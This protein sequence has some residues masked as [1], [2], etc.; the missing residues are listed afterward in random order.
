MIPNSFIHADLYIDNNEFEMKF[1]SI[2]KH[3]VTLTFFI[4]SWVF[5]VPAG[6][7]FLNRGEILLLDVQYNGIHLAT[8][9]VEISDSSLTFQDT[10]DLAESILPYFSGSLSLI[11]EELSKKQALHTKRYCDTY[12]SQCAPLDTFSFIYDS[13]SNILTLFIPSKY[14]K[15]F[16]STGISYFT[17]NN[18]QERAIL[19]SNSLSLRTDFEKITDYSLRT[20]FTTGLSNDSYIYASGYTSNSSTNK[21]DLSSLYIRNDLDNRFYLKAG[22]LLANSQSDISEGLFNYNLLPRQEIIGLQFGTGMHRLDSNRLSKGNVIEVFTV[23]GGRADVYQNNLYLSSINL[24]P[25]Y[26]EV[27]TSSILTN[28]NGYIDLHI[29]ENGNLVRVESHS[30]VKNSRLSDGLPQFLIKA[31]M[32]DNNK[33][34][35]EFA[36]WYD[37]SQHLNW[38]NDISVSSQVSSDN[39]LSEFGASTR[40]SYYIANGSPI[41][42]SN[43]ARFMLGRINDDFVQ[44]QT[45]DTSLSLMNSSLSYRYKNYDSQRCSYESSQTCLKESLVNFSTFFYDT[46]FSMEHEIKKTSLDKEI[47]STNRRQRST[48]SI[49]KQLPL[50]GVNAR[51]SSSLSHIKYNQNLQE[52]FYYVNLSLSLRDN[53]DFYSFNSTYRDDGIGMSA[54]YNYTGLNQNYNI[55]ADQHTTQGTSLHASSSHEMF[56][57]GKLSSSL[58][59]SDYNKSAYLGYSLGLVMTESGHFS[60]GQANINDSSS[61]V[62]FRSIEDKLPSFEIKD[63]SKSTVI[64]SESNSFLYT[65]KSY[66]RKSYNINET[67]LIESNYSDT[68]QLGTG[69]RELFLTPGHTLTH[70]LSSI[71]E[72]FYFGIIDHFLYTKSVQSNNVNDDVIIDEN[73]H[74]FIKSDKDINGFTIYIDEKQ[75]YCK[76][77]ELDIAND[78]NFVNKTVCSLIH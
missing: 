35:T 1:T 16:T 53:S 27:N 25:G 65:T 62:V 76:F 59:L 11:K 43:Y 24:N 77:L 10:D 31:G 55:R 45:L 30:L 49:G 9:L 20:S 58:S 8:Q 34:I 50:K 36:T 40:H 23:Q 4:P 28:Y 56:D 57:K 61:G 21:S 33:A 73:G 44:R 48:L 66:S 17:P 15:T 32:D 2:L 39:L 7:D 68:I 64:E 78:V 26:N 70:E 12:P 13:S 47:F 41:I 18:N 37:T 46:S 60:T 3:I 75:H 5:G 69:R 6:F 19:N 22:K 38:L 67:N 71:K 29:F 74:Y 54:N 72:K 52:N 63:G 42:L 14:T 51:L